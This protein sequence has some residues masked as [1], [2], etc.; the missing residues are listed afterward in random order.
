VTTADGSINP[1]AG[2]P[3]L[4][5]GSVAAY[6]GDFSVLEWKSQISARSSLERGAKF[7]LHEHMLA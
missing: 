1:S 3:L 7:C 5:V 6:Y 2:A 4:E